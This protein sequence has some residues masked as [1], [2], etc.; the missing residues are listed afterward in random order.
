[1]S[2]V[3]RILNSQKE[4]IEKLIPALISRQKEYYELLPEYSW[5]FDSHIKEFENRDY[6]SIL[7]QLIV[8][9]AKELNVELN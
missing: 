4:Y 1:M 9:A 3:I 5:L 6:S 2:D 7:S 8:Y